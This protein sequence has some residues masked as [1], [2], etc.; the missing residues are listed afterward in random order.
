MNAEACWSSHPH[1][2]QPLLDAWARE[3]RLSFTHVYVATT[4]GEQCCWPLLTSLDADPRYR[5][6]Y[7]GPGATVYAL[8]AIDDAG[9]FTRVRP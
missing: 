9:P 4:A 6:I 7:D 8:R 2:W 3:H 5:L 1:E